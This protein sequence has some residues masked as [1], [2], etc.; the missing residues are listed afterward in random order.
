MPHC[1]DLQGVAGRSPLRPGSRSVNDPSGNHR[2]IQG[3]RCRSLFLCADWL[4]LGMRKGL[5]W[6]FA[7]ITLVGG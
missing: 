4:M 3:L 5:S 1:M 6:G 7:E 2:L